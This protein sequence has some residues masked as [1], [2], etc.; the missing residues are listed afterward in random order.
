[1]EEVD[2]R[3]ERGALN[4]VLVQLLWMPAVILRSGFA[5]YVRFWG[6]SLA[7]DDNDHPIRKQMFHQ[8]TQDHGIRDVGHLELVE[9]EHF[10][11]VGDLCCHRFDR[12]DL[13]PRICFFARLAQVFPRAARHSSSCHVARESCSSRQS[14]RCGRHDHPGRSMVQRLEEVRP[15]VHRDHE[16]VKMNAPL[17]SNVGWQC[18][19]KEVHEHTGQSS[20]WPTRGFTL[21]LVSPF[22]CPYIAVQVHSL[23]NGWINLRSFLL[24]VSF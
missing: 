8:T 9:A 6:N 16:L 24:H 14:C 23:R 18:V 7:R 10:H 2:A 19:V 20:Q 12:V 21:L 22:P 17:S 1:M 3:L 13:A 5:R 11:L 15:L 4:T